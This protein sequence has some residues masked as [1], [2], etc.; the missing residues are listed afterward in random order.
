MFRWFKKISLTVVFLNTSFH[1]DDA[2]N[3]INLSLLCKQFWSRNCDL[4]FA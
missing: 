1:E 2:R 4:R 3:R